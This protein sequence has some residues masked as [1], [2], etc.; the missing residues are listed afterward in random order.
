MLCIVYYGGA[1]LFL[2]DHSLLEL[3][4]WQA[5]GLSLASLSI[6]WLIYDQL[7]KSPIR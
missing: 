1:D 6:G 4:P 5:I 7:C 3:Q 2:I